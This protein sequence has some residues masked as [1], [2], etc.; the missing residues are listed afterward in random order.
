MVD[1]HWDDDERRERRSVSDARILERPPARVVASREPI[2]A[3][4]A[5][6]EIEELIL[7]AQ[8][9][10][11]ER[12]GSELHDS[13]GQILV[14]IGL[15]LA[16]LRRVSPQGREVATIVEEISERVQEAHSEIRTLSYLLH[17]PWLEQPGGFE[18]VVC[19]FVEGFARRAGL[20]ARVEVT[21]APLGLPRAAQL[22]LY[23]ILQE[24]LVN[25][26]R[27]A[28]ADLV[29]VRL[30][31]TRRTVSLV[32]QDDGSGIVSVD[33]APPSPGVGFLGMRERIRK[34][35]GDLGIA[36]GPGGTTV[37]AKMPEGSD[38]TVN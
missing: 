2:G 30:T 34:L 23:R 26:Y 5:S 33:G 28:N 10:E 7:N 18:K 14:C 9:E 36:S 19:E 16:R 8:V 35:G 27:H 11:R 4:G 29:T 12:L 37:V 25:V 32:V 17:P 24:A 20:Q 3:E 13:L 31:R 38:E 15:Q 6:R 22:A 21:G 1:L